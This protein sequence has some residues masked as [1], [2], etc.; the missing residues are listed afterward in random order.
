MATNFAAIHV[1]DLNTTDAAQTFTQALYHLAANPQ[2]ALLLR[3]EV[4]QCVEECGWTKEALDKMR[5]VD[6]FLRETLRH[7]GFGIQ[8]TIERKALKDIRLSDGTFIPKGTFTQVATSGIHHDPDVYDNADVF[9]P[10]RFAELGGEREGNKYQMVAVNSASLS[11]GYGKVA[12]PGRF[13]AAALLK[14][15]LAHVVSSFDVK[16]DESRPPPKN[17]VLGHGIVADPKAR[18]MFRKRSD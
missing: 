10:F 14:M 15:L 7:E 9:E 5:R 2:Y 4:R 12:C 16:L 6:S 1:C 11:F 13:F 8:V 17:L 18:V 3:E